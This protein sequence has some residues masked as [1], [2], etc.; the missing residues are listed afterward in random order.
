MPEFV[1]PGIRSN[2]SGNFF[3][4]K[5]ELEILQNKMMCKTISSW[6]KKIEITNGEK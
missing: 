1:L 5:F 6:H 4:A 2:E 3:Y